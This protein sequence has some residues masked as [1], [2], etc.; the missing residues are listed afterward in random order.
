MNNISG[1]ELAELIPGKTLVIFTT[2]YS[3]YAV[4]GFDV[5]AIDYLLKPISFARFLKA[6]NKL[7]DAIAKK[8]PTQTLLFKEGNNIIRIPAHEIYF[9]E[10]VGNYLKIHSAKGTVLHREPMKEIIDALPAEF[11][12]IHKSYIVN[13]QHIS[14]IEPFQL[15]IDNTK[16]PVSPVYKDDLWRKLGIK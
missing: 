13:T 15:T 10:A 11:S 12:R 5:N 2:A 1:I 6:C 8:D 16:I 3:E 14:R 4:K 7:K 9:I